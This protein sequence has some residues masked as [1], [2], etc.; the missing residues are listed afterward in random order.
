[1]LSWN[2]V[3]I[4]L[5]L[6]SQL[7]QTGLATLQELRATE[8]EADVCHRGDRRL[9]T[10]VRETRRSLNSGCRSLKEYRPPEFKSGSPFRKKR[11]FYVFLLMHACTHLYGTSMGVCV[12]LLPACCC[13]GAGICVYAMLA[14]GLS[15]L[16]WYVEILYSLKPKHRRCSESL[17]MCGKLCMGSWKLTLRDICFNGTAVVFPPRT[18][19]SCNGRQQGGLGATVEIS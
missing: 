17:R 3:F 10:G 12:R 6:L 2:A 19:S 18:W 4:F 8:G 14:A 5:F 7:Q 16:D 15:M 13:K 1:M 9:R 11:V